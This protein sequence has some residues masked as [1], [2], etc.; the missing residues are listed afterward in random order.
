MNSIPVIANSSD[1]FIE[2]N[3][4]IQSKNIILFIYLKLLD[5]IQLV[6]IHK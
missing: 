1:S 6:K 3:G 5:Q 4:F 2:F